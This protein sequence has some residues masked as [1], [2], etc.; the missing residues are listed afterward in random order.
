MPA[1]VLGKGIEGREVQGPEGTIQ[2]T[3]KPM[4]L[5]STMAHSPKP[6]EVGKG[7]APDHMCDGGGLERLCTPLGNVAWSLGLEHF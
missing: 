1:G 7:W 4:G 5:N 6:R 3:Y 2:G